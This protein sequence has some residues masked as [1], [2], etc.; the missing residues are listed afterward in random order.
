MVGRDALGDSSPLKQE[1]RI[2]RWRRYQEEIRQKRGTEG[3]CSLGGGRKQ[4]QV[5]DGIV[6]ACEL[7]SS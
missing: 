3:S 2:R 4:N 5:G 7:G 1:D 6:G